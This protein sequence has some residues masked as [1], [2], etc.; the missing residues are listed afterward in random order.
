MSFAWFP[1]HRI[2][3][4]RH[5]NVEAVADFH[6]EKSGRG[7]SNDREEVSIEPDRSTRDRRIGRE[8]ALPK[9]VTDDRARR[10]AAWL[11]VLG[12]KG[13]S[14][15]RGHSEDVEEV[16]VNEQAFRDLNFATLGEIE[17]FRA[18]GN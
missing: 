16:S 9:R 14:N 17:S 11:I 18:P 4:D 6:A 7:Y 12:S 5:S 1:E 13:S 10:A 8:V 3:A 2:G 15:S